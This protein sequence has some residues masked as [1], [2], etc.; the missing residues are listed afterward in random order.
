MEGVC[1][2]EGG[3]ADRLGLAVCV[4]LFAADEEQLLWAANRQLL[5][6]RLGLL[7]LVPSSGL[8]CS[9]HHPYHACALHVMSNTS[10][11]AVSIG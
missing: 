10:S 6:G 8:P 5:A 9:R 7:A 1:V 11:C 4:Y 2:D 3:G